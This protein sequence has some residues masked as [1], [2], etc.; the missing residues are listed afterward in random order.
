[1]GCA[2]WRSRVASISAVWEQALADQVIEQRTCV[3]VAR[4][5]QR[6]RHA[7]TRQKS[8]AHE[9][10]AGRFGHLFEHL[11][12]E[13]A[14]HGLPRLSRQRRVHGTGVL[15]ALQHQ[16]KAGGP[17]ARLR[18]QEAQ[19]RG[20]D[21][22]L[23]GGDRARFVG[24]EAQLVPSDRADEAIGLRA[25]E[26]RGRV[27]AAKHDHVGPV[28]HFGKRL[29]HDFV[30]RRGGAASWKLSSTSTAPGGSRT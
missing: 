1:M 13:V 2:G 24:R 8:G 23:G 9:Q 22:A 10:L 20:I 29:A 26:R 15:Q 19:R 7:D 30:E 18:L 4:Q 27:G 21:L 28:A 17:S 16:H 3:G 12:F 6:R 14:E 11:P 25:C 5:G